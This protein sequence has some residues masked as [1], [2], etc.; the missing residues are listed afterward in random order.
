MSNLDW[1]Q[2]TTKQPKQPPSHNGHPVTCA[3]AKECAEH[4]PEKKIKTR[5][6]SAHLLE[7]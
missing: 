2:Y 5:F 7:Y 6:T 3:K 4:N 1:S